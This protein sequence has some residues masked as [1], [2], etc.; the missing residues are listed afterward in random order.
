MINIDHREA[1]LLDSGTGKFLINFSQTIK[2]GVP[3]LNNSFV[4]KSFL[5]SSFALASILLLSGEAVL[6]GKNKLPEVGNLEDRIDKTLSLSSPQR[7]TRWIPQAPTKNQKLIER[8]E[9]SV[10]K[11]PNE[12]KIEYG[13]F[14]IA[15]SP[16]TKLSPEDILEI[17]N[18][19]LNCENNIQIPRPLIRARK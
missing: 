18:S 15:E 5:V 3:M 4:K 19:H 2:K 9:A 6:A 13:T 8:W 17:Q 14:Y 1:N 10:A 16:R 11:N 12:Y 7:K